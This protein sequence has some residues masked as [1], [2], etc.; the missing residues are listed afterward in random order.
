MA[1]LYIYWSF[2]YIFCCT[3]KKL[4]TLAVNPFVP[5]GLLELDPSLSISRKILISPVGTMDTPLS[6]VCVS[7]FD[8]FVA[9]GGAGGGGDWTTMT[10]EPR[11][12]AVCVV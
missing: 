11:F 2:L 12:S 9:G 6:A 5:E 3:K 7:A 4:A 1:I 8:L 10:L